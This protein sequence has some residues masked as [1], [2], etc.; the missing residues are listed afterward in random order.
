MRRELLRARIESR[1]SAALYFRLAVGWHCEGGP[2]RRDRLR[3]LHR[4]V[5]RLSY[6]P[7]IAEWQELH[8]V[9]RFS[10]VSDPRCDRSSL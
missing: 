6:E 7:C 5:S 8:T 9:I 3:L 4:W 10:S 1:T 2:R